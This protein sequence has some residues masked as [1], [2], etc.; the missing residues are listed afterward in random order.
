MAT[1]LLLTT[2][3]SAQLLPPGVSLETQTSVSVGGQTEVKPDSQNKCPEPY[4]ARTEGGKTICVNTTAS[5]EV[6][7]QVTTQAVKPV[8]GKCPSAYTLSADGESCTKPGVEVSGELGQQVVGSGTFTVAPNAQ[9]GECPAGYLVGVNACLKTNVSARAGTETKVVLDSGA[10]VSASAEEA[11]V[12]V[13]NAEGLSVAIAEGLS[14]TVEA[15]SQKVI[16]EGSSLTV[17]TNAKL[18]LQGGKMVVDGVEV[19]VMPVT[20][21]AKAIEVLQGN[22]GQVELRPVGNK[23]Y[24]YFTKEVPA[25]LFGFI[26]VSMSL[27]ARVDA[28]NETNVKA[29]KSWWAFLATEAEATAEAT[30][31]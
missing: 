25:K 10:S 21:S 18:E 13:N 23:A 16:N 29:G 30:T 20:A 27:T 17:A 2:L 3:V 11:A 31:Q 5:T 19:K 26:P 1:F 6:N 28:T 4:T 9:T 14:V 8:N 7:G 22:F 12:T 15:G 24:Y